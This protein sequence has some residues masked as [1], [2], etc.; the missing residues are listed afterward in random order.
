MLA[1]VH[2]KKKSWQVIMSTITLVM[3]S[4]MRTITLLCTRVRVWILKQYSYL[5]MSTITLNMHEYEYDYFALFSSM[6]TITQKVL[7]LEYEYKY[8]VRLLH[9]WM[10]HVMGLFFNILKELSYENI[11]LKMYFCK[12]FTHNTH[13]IV[14]EPCC[15]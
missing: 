14:T 5:S 7:L 10:I 8:R 4:S 1:K 15:K 2:M 3:Y 9:L 6:S 13:I 11:F 12:E